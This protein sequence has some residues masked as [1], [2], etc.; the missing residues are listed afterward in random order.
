MVN[1]D[2]DTQ[3]CSVLFHHHKSKHVVRESWWPPCLV[4]FLVAFYQWENKGISY[5]KEI[6]FYIEILNLWVWIVTRIGVLLE[7]KA[8]MK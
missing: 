1:S 3:L 8:Y 7:E 4:L 2:K 5:G 6:L